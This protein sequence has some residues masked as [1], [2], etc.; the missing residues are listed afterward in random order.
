MH[1]W[2]GLGNRLELHPQSYLV[3]QAVVAR[4]FSSPALYQ[5]LHPFPY[6]ET[7][8]IKEKLRKKH[9]PRKPPDGTKL[10]SLILP[11]SL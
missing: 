5:T 4:A 6:F 11:K 2:R 7:Q 8:K 9:G 3:V 10:N 1:F